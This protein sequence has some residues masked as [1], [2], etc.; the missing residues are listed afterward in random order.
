[1]CSEVSLIEPAQAVHASDVDAVAVRVDH[2][3]ISASIG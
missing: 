3:Q 2:Q 1:M